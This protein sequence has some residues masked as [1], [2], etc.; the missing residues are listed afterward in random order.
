MPWPQDEA[1]FCL[2]FRFFM[3]LWTHCFL[4]LLQ[5]F[6]PFLVVKL[7]RNDRAHLRPG[8]EPGAF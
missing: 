7:W 4:G 2:V 3:Y 8:R 1:F 6:W 5:N